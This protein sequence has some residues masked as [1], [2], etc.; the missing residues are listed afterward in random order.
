VLWGL[1][2]AG[3]KGVERAIDALTDDLRHV[4]A[5]TGVPDLAAIRRDLVAA[6]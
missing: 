1:A 5:L 6:S 2:T 4:M 3:A